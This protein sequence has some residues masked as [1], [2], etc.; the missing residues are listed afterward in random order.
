MVIKIEDA[1]KAG[2]CTKGI[3]KY[4]KKNNIDVCKV[5]AHGIESDNLPDDVFVRKIIELKIKTMREDNNG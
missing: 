1:I 4:L 5:F 3:I 2:Y